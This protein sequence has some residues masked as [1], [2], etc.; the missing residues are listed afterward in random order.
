MKEIIPFREE[1]TKVLRGTSIQILKEYFDGHKLF[2]DIDFQEESKK[3]IGKIVELLFDKIHKIEPEKLREDVRT[4]LH[5]I[6]NMQN[7]KYLLPVI[8]ELKNVG[9]ETVKFIEDF[10]KPY[11]YAFIL[12]LKD[13]DCFRNHYLVYGDGKS[14]KRW[15]S[16]RTDYVQKDKELPDELVR[17]LFAE[18]KNHLLG[19]GMGKHYDYHRKA[20]GGKEQV[21]IFYQDLPEE[22]PEL[23]NKKIDMKVSRPI[24]KIVFLYDKKRNFVKVFSEDESVR[25]KA[26]RIFAKVVFN[27][28]QIPSSQ[29][30]NRV[31][32]LDKALDQIIEKG[33]I[34]FETSPSL[35]ISKITVVSAA[36]MD[37]KAVFRIASRR[38]KSI[39]SNIR[40]NLSKCF[41]IDEVSENLLPIRNLKMTEIEFYIEYKDFIGKQLY[42]TKRVAMSYKNSIS[43]LSEEDVDFE[44]LDCFRVAGILEISK[45]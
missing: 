14:Y 3:G 30:L 18:V 10:E 36:F 12:F 20:F 44:I 9:G 6:Y 35:N 7:G 16:V 24:K 19:E 25:I 43:N 2:L 26:H 40:S 8:R 17:K 38:T 27:R 42:K 34:I 23:Q 22:K 41:K 45:C 33:E 31:C 11:D 32:R 1:I 4:D 5:R 39:Y 21:V 13:P 29:P 37:S 15:W 28:D